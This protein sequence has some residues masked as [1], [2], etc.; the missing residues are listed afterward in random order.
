MIADEAQI[1]EQL[2]VMRFAVGKATLLVVPMPQKRFLA[3]CANEM[4]DMPILAQSGD[5]TLFNRPTA[6]A[7]N[8]NAH[9]IVASQ[10]IQFVHVVGRESWTTFDFTR[11]R[12][13][14]NV[15]CGAVEMVSVINF[16]AET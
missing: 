14:F 11:R 1:A 8:G 3:F 2:M 16:A 9:F 10:A 7:A 4:L 5:H 15:A 6:G 13:Q 12:I